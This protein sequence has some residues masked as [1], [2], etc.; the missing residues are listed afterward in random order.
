MRFAIFILLFCVASFGQNPRPSAA[1]GQNL[2][3]RQWVENAIAALS[4]GP[5]AAHLRNFAFSGTIQRQG[6][7]GTERISVR[8]RGIYDLHI[9]IAEANGGTY[10]AIK[11][12]G[13]GGVIQRTNARPTAVRKNDRAG[14]EVFFFPLPGLLSDVLASAGTIEDLGSD[15]VG[16]RA[17]QHVAVTRQ[18]PVGADQDG[19]MAKH[20]K[21]DFFIDSQN[22]QILKIEHAAADVSGRWTSHRT[23]TFANYQPVNGVLIPFG[24]T[25]F[26]DGQQTRT[27][28]VNSIDVSPKLQDSDFQF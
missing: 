7:A 4:V 12:R 3:A 17:V 10:S 21:I 18:F 9:E 11:A 27:I 8:A 1:S 14:T 16:G 26:L 5:D 23:V 24:L 25:E 2:A 20:S 19:V 6:E 13:K 22:F 15:S 28:T